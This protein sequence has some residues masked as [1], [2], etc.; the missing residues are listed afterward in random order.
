VI[1]A[2]EAIVIKAVANEATFS[3]MLVA[4]AR[5]VTCAQAADM[6]SAK[7]S[8]ASSTKTAHVGSAKTTDVTSAEP[9]DVPSAKAAAHVASATTAAAGLCPRGK[10]AA[11]KH[12]ARQDQHHS[13]SHDI[14]HW[15]GGHSATGP[16]QTLVCT[17]KANANI[18]MHW[19]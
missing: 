3:K 17:S 14:L 5:K 12:G 9:T 6:T 19:R 11:R 10:Y 7:T 15:D 2:I 1:R 4:D 8:N 18:A 13:S 16:C